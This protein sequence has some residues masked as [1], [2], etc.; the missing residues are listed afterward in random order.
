MKAATQGKDRL[1]VLPKFE[2]PV[3]ISVEELDA[4]VKKHSEALKSVDTAT[5]NVFAMEKQ[6]GSSYLLPVV[7]YYILSRNNAFSKLKKQEF[8][9]L[10]SHVHAGYRQGNPYHNYLHATDVVQLSHYFITKCDLKTVAKM[11]ELDVAG[12]LLAALIHDLKHP[13]LSS[14]FL[15]NLQ[16]DLALTYNNQSILENHHLAESFRLILREHD[17]AIFG[18]LKPEEVKR[19][20]KLMITCVLSTDMA[21]HFQHLEEFVKQRSSADKS[22]AAEETRKLALLAEVLHAADIGTP[23][24]D[25]DVFEAWTERVYK[26]FFHQGDLEKSLGLPVSFGCDREKTDL[27]AGQLGYV[28]KFVLPLYE[29]ITLSVPKA[30]DL[31]SRIKTLEAVWR[32]KK[33]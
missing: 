30:A 33:K 24:R 23:T 25:L 6:I 22:P 11:D 5:F 16:H 19:V 10:V 13:G 31:V 29:A 17:C 4:L 18:S 21:N 2:S 20:R 32:T 15:E 27:H 9:H 26:E 28:C 8:A 7:S 3:Y 12:F 1:D 14:A